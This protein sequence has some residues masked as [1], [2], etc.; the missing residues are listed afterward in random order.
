LIPDECFFRTLLM[1]SDLAMTIE[2]QTLTYI[3]WRPPRPGIM[4][5]GDLPNLQKSDCLFARKFD[6]KADPQVLD[7]LDAAAKVVTE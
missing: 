1:N 2:P 6:A 7:Q 4:T 3:N 5:L